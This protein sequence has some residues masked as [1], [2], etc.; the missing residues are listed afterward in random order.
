MADTHVPILKAMRSPLWEGGLLRPPGPKSLT[1]QP[2]H[3]YGAQLVTQPVDSMMPAGLG[4]QR[5]SAPG[6]WVV[7]P[8]PLGRG[9]WKL[10]STDTPAVSSSAASSG[11]PWEPRREEV[12]VRSGLLPG[13]HLVGHSGGSGGS[14]FSEDAAD[15]EH[16][17]VPG[18]GLGHPL[19][20]CDC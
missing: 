19:L 7:K 5:K 15:Q 3:S 6:P 10:P 17:V 1:G 13:Q 2:G 16:A 14:L 20:S 11:P 8:L 9:Q 18:P 4:G 12:P